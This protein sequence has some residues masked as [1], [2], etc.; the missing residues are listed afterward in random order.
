MRLTLWIIGLLMCTTVSHAQFLNE[1]PLAE[2][3][4]HFLEV[5]IEHKISSNKFNVVVDYGG[6]VK[7]KKSEITDEE[8]KELKFHSPI[9]V[10]NLIKQNGFAFLNLYAIESDGYV[11]SHYLFEKE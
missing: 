9:E 7:L 1:Q 8:G 6:D 4:T 10:L 2:I 5:V 11:I 3:E